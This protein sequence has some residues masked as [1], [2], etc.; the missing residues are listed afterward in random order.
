MSRKSYRQTFFISGNTY[1]LGPLLQSDYSRGDQ[2]A[3]REPHATLC[4]FSCGSCT[5]IEECVSYIRLLPLSSIR[6]IHVGGRYGG[7]SH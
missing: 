5:L 4:L 6:Y 7:G 3:A 2:S 1:L